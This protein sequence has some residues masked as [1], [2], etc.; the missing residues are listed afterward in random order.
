MSKQAR[1]DWVDIWIVY[2]MAMQCCFHFNIWKIWKKP[3]MSHFSFPNSDPLVTFQF[4][5]NSTFVTDI[6]EIFSLFNWYK[7]IYF[8]TWNLDASLGDKT[9]CAMRP[10][11]IFSWWD[12]LKSLCIYLLFSLKERMSPIEQQASSSQRM[13]LYEPS[14]SEKKTFLFSLSPSPISFHR[15][16]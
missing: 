14:D 9:I 13:L 5:S 3:A 7:C 6:T 8:Q 12:H 11:L 10:G 15:D 4:L 2:G 16:L 1:M